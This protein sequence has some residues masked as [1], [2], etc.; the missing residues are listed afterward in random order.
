MDGLITL[1]C[2]DC[3]RAHVRTLVP[4]AVRQVFAI[5]CPCGAHHDVRTFAP[6]NGSTV[7]RIEY[8]RVQPVFLPLGA[9]P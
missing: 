8:R 1:H 6:I 9:R 4:Q 2:P 7:S 5:A 3:R